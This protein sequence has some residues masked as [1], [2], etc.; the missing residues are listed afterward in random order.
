MVINK[1]RKK[2]IGINSR[3]LVFSLELFILK[4]IKKIASKIA[5][6]SSARDMIEIPLIILM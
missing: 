2:I 1:Y 6:T 5:K 4:M 3:R